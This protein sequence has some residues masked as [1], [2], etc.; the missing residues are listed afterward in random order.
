MPVKFQEE[1]DGK[2]LVID[3]RGKLTAAEYQQFLPCVE[4]GIQR[5]GKI[6]MLV[7]LYDFHGWSLGALWE[8]VK[9]DWKHFRDIERLA[10]VGERAWERGMAIF[11]RPFTTAQMRYF[12]RSEADK[13]DAWIR[14][15]LSPAHAV[16]SPTMANEATPVSG[17]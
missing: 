5:H 15:E 17:I 16:A 9:F 4:R 8:D 6:R 10:L 14:A 12:D 1:A 7:H 3:L 13:A 2:L 11:C